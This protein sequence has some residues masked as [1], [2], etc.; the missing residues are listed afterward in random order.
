MTEK[1]KA[2]EHMGPYSSNP[3]FA[4]FASLSERAF[5]TMSYFLG[6]HERKDE[7][8]REHL[9]SRMIYIAEATSTAI[10]LNGSW[11]LI[12]P[13]LSLLRDRYEQVVRYSYLI[14]QTDN[15]ELSNYIHSGT[16]YAT[17]KKYEMG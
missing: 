4:E 1:P 16:W 13:G 7:S 12:H 11:G 6:G 5:A 14:W 10:R 3:I 17:A 2:L 9:K 8:P 15:E